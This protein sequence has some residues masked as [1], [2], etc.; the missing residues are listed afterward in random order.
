VTRRPASDALVLFGATGDLA[1]KMLYPA[2]QALVK[3]E[4]FDMPVIGVSRSEWNDA[5]LR[6]RASES[7]QRQHALDP[8]AFGKLAG[9][10]HYVS[11]DYRD[12]TTF[13]KLKKAL[14]G[15]QHPLY[16]LAIPPETYGDVVKGLGRIEATRGAR[17]V[18]EKPFGRDL[19]SA[20]A[21]N[22]TLH[23][24]FDEDAILRIDHYLG[25]ETVLNLPYFRFANSFIEPIWNRNQIRSVQI[26]MA[27]TFGIGSRGKLYESLG[28]I[29]D[30][31]Q[32]HMLQVVAMLAMEPPQGEHDE[33]FRDEKVKVFKSIRPL[34]A[35]DV[36]RGQYRGY[37]QEADVAWDS[38]TE[39]FAAL[40]LHLD[41]WR[42]AGVPF[43][44]RAGK[45]LPVTAT[46]VMVEL[47]RPPQK[48]FAERRPRHANHVRFQLGP[49]RM[50]IGIGMRAKR[51]GP[52]M[53]GEDMEL[54]VCDREHEGMSAY[55]R[56]IGDAIHGEVSQFDREDG[57]EQ[58]WRIVDPVLQQA[59]PIHEY[60]PGSW[61]PPQADA[62][63]ARYGGWHAPRV[64][65]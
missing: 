57:V 36:V 62:L 41:S 51:P 30:V 21:L 19:D 45:C 8:H 52:E 31:V 10:L 40:R 17:V 3:R 60:A 22:R 1:N 5:Q 27:E 55:E 11:G 56:L 23:G 26:T 58:A 38:D 47:K 49:D 24:L 46:E 33:A 6:E 61:G 20:R 28:A 59:T 42:W 32:N 14:D 34:T 54:L 44:I 50:A 13:D 15:A 65:K 29:R 37:R 25:K 2:L 18:A 9:M 63:T 16:Y 4:H 39:T 64:Q 12:P 48:V 7:V 35:E 53:V 43:F